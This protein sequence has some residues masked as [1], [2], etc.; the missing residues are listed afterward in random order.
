[1]RRAVV[2]TVLAATLP[3]GVRSQTMGQ[4]FTVPPGV[5]DME[6]ATLTASL[7]LRA[8]KGAPA[9][10]RA[11]GTVIDWYPATGGF[12]LTGG[13]RDASTA[14]DEPRRGGFAPYLG[15]GWQGAVL[16]DAVQ[17]GLDFGA[18][19]RGRPHVRVIDAPTADGENGQTPHAGFT[20]PFDPVVS[21][22]FT[23]RF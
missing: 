11:T 12:R 14:D 23:Y 20:L 6:P 9:E 2:V 3:S 1:M 8:V 16:G 15:L 7:M 10:D 19:F 18:L 17:V 5:L 22:T 21:I 4:P 13:F